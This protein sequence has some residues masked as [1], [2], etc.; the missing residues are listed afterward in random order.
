[1]F[2]YIESNNHIETF[3]GEY[4]Q[5]SYI[6]FNSYIRHIRF[7]VLEVFI[8]NIDTYPNVCIEVLGF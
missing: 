7:N 3:V 5:L 4:I 6:A 2:D 8:V 1:M